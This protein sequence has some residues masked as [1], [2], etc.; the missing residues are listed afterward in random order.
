ML[1][2][3][4]IPSLFVTATDTE[5]GKTVVAGAIADWFR[6]QGLRVAVLKPAATGCLHRREGL[7]SEDAEFLAA[8][9]DARHPLDLIC[10]QR[11]VEPLA[12]AIAAERAKQPLDWDAIERS[13]RIMSADSDVMIVE[14]VGGVRVPMDEKHT[15]LD[16][17]KWLGAP[18]VVVARPNLGTI[19]HTLL[20]VQAIRD[21]GIKLVGVVIN[22][23][24]AD[25]ASIAEET[26][27]SVIEKWGKVPILCIVPDKPSSGISLPPDISAAIGQVDWRQ[28]THREL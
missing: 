8:C 10:P 5:V 26:N 16:M 7:V 6:R 11:F 1:S 23:F 9:A 27:P 25:G 3:I 18:A 12:P 24:R 28:F 14:G 19:N 2:P 15:V 13:I 4:P 21:A 22:R 20:T 17:M